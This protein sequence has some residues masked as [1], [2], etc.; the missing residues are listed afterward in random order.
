MD[1][2]YLENLS[3]TLELILLGMGT[4]FSSLALFA[5]LIWILTNVDDKFNAYKIKKYSKKVETKE[6]S[7]DH[8]D[9]IIA[10]IST[11]VFIFLNKPVKIHKIHFLETTKENAWETSG[12]NNLMSSHIIKRD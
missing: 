1:T 4:V 5:F 3:R 7:E 6:V 9:E 2:Q 8:N 12:R 10:V 11:A